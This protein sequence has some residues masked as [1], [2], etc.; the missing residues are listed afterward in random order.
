MTGVEARPNH[1]QTRGV[2]YNVLN[3]SNFP[4]PSVITVGS[5]TYVFGT[6]DGA[7]HNVPVTSNRNFGNA[8]GWSAITDAF[9]STNVP[10]MGAGGWA[11]QLTTWAPDV[12]QLVGIDAMRTLIGS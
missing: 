7:G 3:G 11:A 4:D 9:P 6:N 1:F 12:N 8:T 5:T 2:E 10:A